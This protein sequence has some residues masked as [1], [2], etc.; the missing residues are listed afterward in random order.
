MKGLLEFAPL[1]SSIAAALAAVAALTT[2]FLLSRRAADKA[3]VESFSE[4][5]REFWEDEDMAKVRLWIINEPSYATIEPILLRRFP[6]N[7]KGKTDPTTPNTLSIDD[8]KV[9][10]MIDRFCSYMVQFEFYYKLPASTKQRLLWRPLYNRSWMRQLQ[11][12]DALREY[13][14]NT[15]P[16]FHDA[17]A[18]STNSS[19]PLARELP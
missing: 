14:N 8:N 9:L 19:M 7:E 4:I 10:E 13:V 11:A 12:R 17:P 2:A 18:C 3:W 5:Y 15:W 16:Y 6:P 1:V